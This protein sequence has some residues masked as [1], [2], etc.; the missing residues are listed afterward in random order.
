MRSEYADFVQ[1]MNCATVMLVP[2]GIEICP[3]CQFDGSLSWIDNAIQE[4]EWPLNE[5]DYV[6]VDDELRAAIYNDSSSPLWYNV[7]FSI[8][9]YI[10]VSATNQ[11]EAESYAHQILNDHEPQISRIIRAGVGIEIGDVVRSDFGA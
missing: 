6:E 3:A 11:E 2:M 8:E 9:G 5:G 4:I 1:C 10:M 7:H